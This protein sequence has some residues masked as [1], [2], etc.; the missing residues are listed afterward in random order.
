METDAESST[1]KSGLSL[2]LATPNDVKISEAVKVQVQSVPG[3]SRTK[4]LVLTALLFVFA[5]VG[6]A[7]WDRRTRRN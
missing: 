5:L 6:K 3:M 1:S 4:L 7:L 2:W